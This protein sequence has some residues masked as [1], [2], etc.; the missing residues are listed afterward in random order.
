MQ[1]NSTADSSTDQKALWID[2]YRR[3][4]RIRM[5]ERGALDL[6]RAGKMPGF[7][8]LSIGQE[9]TP[10]GVCCALRDDDYITT[11]HRGHGDTIA[12]GGAVESAFAELFGKAS[13][14]CHAK[15]GSL[16]IADF[17][18]NILGANGMVAAGIPIG[19]GAALSAKYR[20]TDQVVVCF[21]GDGAV[22]S[23]PTHESMNM[24]A[25]WKLPV[26]FV[27]QNNQ[28]AESTP[29]A[30]YQG[31]PDIV[32]WAEGYGMPAICVDGND[33][34]AVYE[35]GS[36]SV[37][38]AR[39]GEGPTFIESLT[40]RWYG[41]NIGDPGTSRPKEEVEAWKAKDPLPRFYQ[42]ILN[43]Q[44]ASESEL[45][46]VETEE[47]NRIDTA[48][49]AAESASK[50]DLKAVFEDVYVDPVLGAKAMRGVRP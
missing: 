30:D 41:H 1:T 26:L 4:V 49:A 44:V 18:K 46:T 27:R 39:K 31:M 32:R 11:T 36:A 21:F 5:F 37:D 8:H 47:Q 22:G 40:Y 42:V 7:M 20:G 19:V 10:V 50:P 16:H 28:Y 6:Y 35:A 13:G 38:R 34:L 43:H 48:I 25:L 29:N 17:S 12:K 33:V 15:G 2:M 24:A 23:G 9:A 3:M 45:H 14:I